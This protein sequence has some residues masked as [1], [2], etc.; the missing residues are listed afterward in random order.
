MLN[1][2]Q[3]NGFTLIELVVVMFL[4]GIMLSFTIPRFQDAIETDKTN[5]FSR[6]LMLKGQALKES[7]LRGKTRY[8]LHIGM[9]SGT[10]W[11]SNESM[12]ED[13]ILELEENGYKLPEDL[14]V[15]DV[16]YP[17]KGIVSMGRADICFYKNGYSDKVLI[18]IE[19]D[20]GNQRTFLIE[21]FLSKIKRYEEY[22]GF[23]G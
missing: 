19:D 14:R 13:A 20:D 8:T 6:W 10:L 1:S 9:D 12:T 22:V 11:V 18:H 23:E 21:P 2:N 17:E 7:A 16:E 15:L 3:K 5:K 4:F